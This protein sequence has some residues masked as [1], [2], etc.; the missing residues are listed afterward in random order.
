M[1]AVGRLLNLK[2][3]WVWDRAKTTRVFLYGPAVGFS[4]KRSRLFF[5]FF[6]FVILSLYENT[7]GQYC[8]LRRRSF[9]AAVGPGGPRRHGLALLCSWYGPRG[10]PFAS[11][12]LIAAQIPRAASL[13]CLQSMFLLLSL[14]VLCREMSSSRLTRRFQEFLFVS[15]QALPPRVLPAISRPPLLRYIPSCLFS[16]VSFFLWRFQF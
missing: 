9:T 10:R 1:A 14:P 16:V 11:S 12:A 2:G 6:F 5:F 15:V 3:H 13:R 8:C 4:S 7:S